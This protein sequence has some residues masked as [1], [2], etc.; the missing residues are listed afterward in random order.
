M[1]NGEAK[2]PRLSVSYASVTLR[3]LRERDQGTFSVSVGDRLYDIITLTINDCAKE[4]VQN[5]ATVYFGSIPR[6]AEYLEFTPLHNRDQP[7]IL[8][9]RTDPQA[10]KGGR[11]QV[12]GNTWEMYKLTQADNGFYAFRKNDNTL[13]NRMKLSVED[14]DREY[15][16]KVG[17]RLV[18]LYP[19]EF[20]M[21]TVTFIPEGETEHQ[22]VIRDGTSAAGNFAWRLQVMHEG[23]EIYPVESTDSGT[24]EFRDKQGN[25]AMTAIVELESDAT[26]LVVA[27]VVGTI[28][29]VIIC[30]CCVRKCCCKK[31]S[32]KRNESAPQTAAT[33]ATYYHSQDTNQPAGTSYSPAPSTFSYQPRNLP[34]STGPITTSTGPSVHNPVNIHVTSPQPQVAVSGDQEAAPAPSMGSDMFSSDYEPKFDLKGLRF[35]SAPPLSSDSTFCD[36]YTS[37]KLNFL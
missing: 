20:T 16:I 37:D 25:L 7:Q 1:D 15:N 28:L 29:V 36:V 2:D 9:N 11:V 35:P 8:W 5:Y 13:L 18:I 30:C 27:A 32:S 3:D 21:W 22:T 24:F 4:F 6:K 31:S 12:R 14:Y 23:I 17:E 34:V 19:A 33:P 10:N 26:L